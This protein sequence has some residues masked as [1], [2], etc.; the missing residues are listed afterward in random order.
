[1][2]EA[3]L[4]LA[5]FDGS[6]EPSDDDCALVE[7]IKELGVPYVALINKADITADIHKLYSELEN[8]VCVSALTGEGFDALERKVEEMFIDGEI[9]IVNDP[10]VTGARQYAALSSAAELLEKAYADINAGVSLD[11][12]C[13][14]VECAMSALGEVDGREIGEEIVSDIFSR[15]CVGK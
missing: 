6:R 15:F 2:G 1:M 11:V 9:D 10:V 8:T 4:I 14:G 7:R 3:G 5:V 13:V 12:C